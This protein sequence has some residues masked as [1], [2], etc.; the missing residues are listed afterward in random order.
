M[1]A[2]D[3]CDDNDPN[4]TT[5]ANDSDCDG[6]LTADDCND[7]DSNSTTVDIDADCD[8]VLTSQNTITIRIYIN[9]R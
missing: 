4:S 5:I 6:V 3:D 7:F 8:G 2:F 9:C 1:M